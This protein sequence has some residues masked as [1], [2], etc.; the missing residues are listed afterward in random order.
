VLSSRALNK[1]YNAE[2]TW[3]QQNFILNAKFKI[4]PIIRQKMET[5][6]QNPEQK[7]KPYNLALKG[8]KRLPNGNFKEDHPKIINVTLKKQLMW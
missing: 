3:I 5:N 8:L 6:S 4:Y 7:K 2:D 1:F